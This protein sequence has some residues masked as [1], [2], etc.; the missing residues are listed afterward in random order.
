MPARKHEPH[1]I[2][3]AYLEARADDPSLSLR[4]Y[5]HVKGLPYKYVSRICGRQVVDA[6]DR[7]VTKAR[8]DMEK[9]LGGQLAS[10][11]SQMAK[12]NQTLFSHAAKSLLDNRPGPNG[13]TLP[14]FA[15]G[16]HKDALMQLDVTF[17]G[18]VQAVQ[19]LTGKEP[20]IPPQDVPYE[21][22][23]N[24]PMQPKVLLGKVKQ[25]SPPKGN[26]RRNGKRNGKASR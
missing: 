14:P 17:R 10:T 15:P 1:L 8:A 26:G 23:W 2:V 20:M 16:D 11:L 25:L 12:V 9:K 6:W 13:T 22:T 19:T 3:G 18:F 21:T 24:P 7:V 4:K 5:C